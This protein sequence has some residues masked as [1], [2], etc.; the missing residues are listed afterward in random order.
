V[1]FEFLAVI[2]P[3]EEREMPMGQELKSFLT[4]EEQ[5]VSLFRELVKECSQNSV[6]LRV[7]PNQEPTLK[8]TRLELTPTLSTAAKIVAVALDRGVVYLTFGRATPFELQTE[9]GSPGGPPPLA[10]IKAL[11]SAVMQGKFE[12]KLWLVDSQVFKCTGKIALGDKVVTIHYRGSFHPFGKT[13]KEHIKYSPY[14]V[15][16]RT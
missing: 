11:C 5:I 10:Q 8:G 16:A 13:K 15:K 9:N 6:S 12:E 1:A 4:L 3:R 7:Q 2:R 14:L